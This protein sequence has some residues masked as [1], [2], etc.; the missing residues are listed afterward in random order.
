MDIHNQKHLTLSNR[1]YIEQELMQGST[2]SSI[3]KGL[4]K[5]PTTISKE[6]RKNSKFVPL[7]Y[8]KPCQICKYFKDC[9]VTS[10][11]M[12]CLN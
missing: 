12:H 6:V 9:D 7:K 5:D 8:G 4:H 10:S 11:E 1:I 3:A 2:F